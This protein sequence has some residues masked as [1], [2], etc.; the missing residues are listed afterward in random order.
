[1]SSSLQPHG[2]QHARLPCPSLSPIFCS[3]SCSLSW[4]CHPTNHLILCCPLLLVPSS[5]SQHQGLFQGVSFSHSGGQSIGASASVLVLNIKYWFPLGLNSLIS[6]LSRGLPGVFSSTTIWK[7]QFFSA[8]PSLWS[9]FTSVHD[10]L[11]NRSFDYT[12]LCWQS[13][14]SDV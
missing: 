9:T 3:S 4:W 2:L 8:Q 12:D 10:C 11:K 6:L 1:M 7:H 5:L 13:D 14:V